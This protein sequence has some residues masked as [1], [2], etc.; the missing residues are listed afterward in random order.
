LKAGG[1][2]I[3]DPGLLLQRMRPAVWTQWQM[4]HEIDPWDENRADRRAGEIAAA[5]LNAQGAKKTTG[6][7]FTPADFMDYSKLQTD[8]EDAHKQLSRSLRALL[9]ANSKPKGK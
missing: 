8:P 5:T 2:Y 4:L 6:E 9:Q 1:E 3:V 7:Q